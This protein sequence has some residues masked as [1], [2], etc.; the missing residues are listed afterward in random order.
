MPQQC[1]SRK[2]SYPPVC[3][4]HKVAVVQKQIAIDANVPSLGQVTCNMCPVSHMVVREPARSYA[5]I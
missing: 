1:F 5:R 2:D 4:V 3:A